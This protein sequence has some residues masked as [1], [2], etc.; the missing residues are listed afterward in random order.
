VNTVSNLGWGT[1]G[2][3]EKQSRRGGRDSVRDCAQLNW[4]RKRNR[5]QQCMKSKGAEVEEEYMLIENKWLGKAFCFGL[6][7]TDLQHH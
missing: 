7:K 4:E 5:K 1:K 2:K 6:L 3:R